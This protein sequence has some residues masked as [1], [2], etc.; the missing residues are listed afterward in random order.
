ME[1]GKDLIK[2]N[3]TTILLGVLKDGEKYGYE[4]ITA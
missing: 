4:I 2:G 3:V 1:I